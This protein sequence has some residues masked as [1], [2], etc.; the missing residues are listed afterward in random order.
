M[1]DYQVVFGYISAVIELSVKM[2]PFLHLIFFNKLVDFKLPHI[3]YCIS[4]IIIMV[5]VGEN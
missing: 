5:F 1:H 2:D 3:T 4:C